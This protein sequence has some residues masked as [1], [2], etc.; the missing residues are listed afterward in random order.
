M[1]RVLYELPDI[2]PA[3]EEGYVNFLP[4]KISVLVESLRYAQ[5]I[6][7]L[8]YPIGTDPLVMRRLLER[9]ADRREAPAKP[10]RD[11][12]KIFQPGASQG[13]GAQGNAP[14]GPGRALH[15]RW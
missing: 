8:R 3:G 15:R 13:P 5:L 11:R 1:R 2:M 10:S 12:G 6:V 4:A 7:Q 9:E 14:G